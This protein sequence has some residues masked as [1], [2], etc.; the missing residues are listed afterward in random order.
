VRAGQSLYSTRAI[1]MASLRPGKVFANGMF[2]CKLR[3][4]VR[5]DR[6]E[7]SSLAINPFT[8][9][10]KLLDLLES[11]TTLAIHVVDSCYPPTE[12]CHHLLLKLWS[13][14]MLKKLMIS[15]AVFSMVFGF[16]ANDASARVNK[17]CSKCE[18][19]RV[20]K[21]RCPKQKC[22]KPQKHC[23]S[24]CGVVPAS[25]CSACSGSCSVS[26]VQHLAPVAD[27]GPAPAAAPVEPAPTAPSPSAAEPVK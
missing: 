3:N 5:S 2:K 12:V 19:V 4:A 26:D 14:G 9:V 10:S 8:S 20:A 22:A 17:G 6:C 24:G 21:V 13:P 15:V 7:N 27:P 1:G 11:T 18:P 16:I 25:S 23:P